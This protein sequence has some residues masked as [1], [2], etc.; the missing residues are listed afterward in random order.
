MKILQMIGRALWGMAVFN[1]PMDCVVRHRSGWSLVT[2][3]SLTVGVLFFVSGQT[4]EASALFLFGCALPIGVGSDRRPT[5]SF[6]VAG[7]YLWVVSELLGL[8]LD[9]MLRLAGVADAAMVVLV[10]K[11]AAWVIYVPL[12]IG[13]QKKLTEIKCDHKF[14]EYP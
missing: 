6:W 5:P 4:L 7:G 14:R 3:M 10:W 8:L 1:L 11:L 13:N 12:M 2:M 9:G